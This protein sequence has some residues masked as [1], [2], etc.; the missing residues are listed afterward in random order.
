MAYDCASIHAMAFSSP[1]VIWDG[2][3]TGIDGTIP[4]PQEGADN[5]RTV[6]LIAPMVADYRCNDDICSSLG[7]PPTAVDC[8]GN[9]I[10]DLCEI[11]HDPDL[12]ADQDGLL[13]SCAC[14]YDLNGDGAVNGGDLALVLAGWNGTEPDLN[15]DGVVAGA[16]LAIILAMW[17]SCP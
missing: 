7:L 8:N 5:A 12:D 11:A 15:G 4:G 9:H 16:D 10:P 2:V 6:E 14:P 17:E 3:P 13:D 1:T